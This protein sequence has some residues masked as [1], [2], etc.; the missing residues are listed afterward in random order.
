M[1]IS[2]PPAPA[3]ENELIDALRSDA[4][5]A[6]K[7][8]T[9]KQL[10]IYGTSAAAPELA[11]LLPDDELSSWARIALEAIPGPD[12]AAALRQA[13]GD[14]EGQLQVG[15][16]NSLGVIRDEQAASLLTGLLQNQDEQVASAAAVAL[17]RI[18]G[19]EAARSLIAALGTPRAE[20]R[21]A[22]AEGCILSAERLLAGGDRAAAVRI[23][24]AVRSSGAPK[25]PL[26]EGVRGAILARG[27]DG[28]PLLLEQLHAKDED[29]FRIAL[30]TA[31]ELP[32]A[33]IDRAMAGELA[34][35][36]PERSALLVQAMADR[37]QTV[38]LTAIIRAAEQG[39][40]QLRAAA[41]GSLARVGN[42]TCLPAMIQT[43]LGKDKE[44]AELAKQTIAQLPGEGV[45]AEV[46]E[47]LDAAQGDHLAL[48]IETVGRRRIGAL[49]DVVKKLD[50]PDQQVRNA[51]HFALGETVGLKDLPLLIT[52]VVNPVRPADEEAA[53][54]ALVAACIRMPDREACAAELGAAFEQVDA[55]DT[56]VALL[57]IL[58]EMGGQNALA[59]IGRAAG[60]DDSSLQD[61]GTR[62]LG[63]WM[64]ADAAP[65][66]LK[67]SSELP[68]G[69]YQ[70]RAIRGYVRIAR[71]LP[72]SQQQ[73][74]E[75]CRAAL[76]AASRVN[77]QVMVLEV[78][79]R[80][81]SRANLRLAKEAAGRPELKDAA[82]KASQA[83]AQQ[84]EAE[85]R[86]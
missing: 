12:S 73:R 9:C 44:L 47:A 3:D 52:R 18:G 63:T 21:S 36:A 13:A 83:I 48:L 62:I 85:R 53:R 72:V 74:T 56:K 27:P 2:H 32:G 29:F 35:L 37:P 77:E 22:I 10:A 75:M 82:E 50:S 8:I 71:Q 43:A 64:T 76:E 60:S 1:E 80:Y 30:S 15:A 31:R 54:K 20:L 49:N 61:A 16:I 5:A 25:Q 33:E 67:L 24:D 86:G 57:D 34:G 17:G 45:D 69:N 19:P 70:I 6:D 11:K 39:P 14:L 51:A 79:Q 58:G 26:L 59:I 55:A 38:V 66:L 42:E 41:I 7:A 78:L 68:E 28:I 23:Y 4:P 84:L 65:V 40:P 81:P 46:L